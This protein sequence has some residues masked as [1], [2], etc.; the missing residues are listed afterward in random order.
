[1]EIIKIFPFGE[2]AVDE[3]V[4]SLGSASV[5]HY[6]CI[7]GTIYA[8]TEIMTVIRSARFL[9]LPCMIER[10]FFQ[11]LALTLLA[12]LGFIGTASA[13]DYSK[14]LT[15]S[16][17]DPSRSIGYSPKWG[18]N[19]GPQ[20]KKYHYDTRMI[21]AAQIAQERARAH[22]TRSCWRYVKKALVAAQVL[23]TYPTTAY[24]KQAGSDLVKQ[25]FRPIPVSDPYKAPL[26]SV[27]V[28]GGAGAGHVEIRTQTGFVSDFESPTPSSRPLIGVY[29]KPS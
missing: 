2:V 9:P 13:T 19:F 4:P 21:R 18:F 10:L 11:K 15:N 6:K 17:Y 8:L 12:L 3:G 1:M 22:S 29:I 25:G 5:E 28:Y 7:E 26:G 23:D 27:L 16:M 20:A 24:A 14:Q